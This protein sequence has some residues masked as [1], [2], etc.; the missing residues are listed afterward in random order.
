MKET[1]KE[2]FLEKPL[3]MMYYCRFVAVGLGRIDWE[4]T[5]IMT[6][7]SHIILLAPKKVVFE[8]MCKLLMVK[9]P[10][11]GLQLMVSTGLMRFLFPE[12]HA[13]VEFKNNQG[14]WHSKNVWEHTLGVV[15][16]SPQILEVRLAALWHDCAKPQT[17]AI[18]NDNVHFYRHEEF[19]AH[20]WDKTANYYEADLRLKDY[21]GDLI[22]NHLQFSLL[23]SENPSDTALRRFVF[24]AGN[25]LDNFFYLSMA[26]ITSAN[27][28]KVT[29]CQNKCAALKKRIDELLARDL[30]PKTKLPTGLGNVL[31]DQLG[32]Y[33]K[34]LGDVMNVLHQMLVDKM[35]DS[36]ADFV[37]EAKKV[38]KH[39]KD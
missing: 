36:D 8:E 31:M 26:D 38:M 34:D 4:T 11:A 32:L 3:R 25:K 6:E 29:A 10:T 22:S 9:D 19:G 13:M 28:D 27:L 37:E 17:F 23:S 16:Q 30:V 5:R 2:F 7:M 12:I 18:V 33:G 35:L 14:K 39:E 1:P 20:K 15:R 24:R 21:V